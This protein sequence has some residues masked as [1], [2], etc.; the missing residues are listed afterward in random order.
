VAQ[1]LVYQAVPPPLS[2]LEGVQQLPPGRILV[3]DGNTVKIRTYWTPPRQARETVRNV[4]EAAELVR[5]ELEQAVRRQMMSERPLGVFL[6]GGVDSSALVAMAARQVSHRLQTFSVGF[7][8]ADEQVLT[9]WPWAKQVAE[10]YDTD[11]HEVVLTEETFRERLPHVLTS[12]DQPTSD[13]INSYYVSLAASKGVTVAL[14]GTGGDELFLGYGR[15]AALLNQY[16]QARRFC[17][18]PPRYVLRIGRMLAAIPGDM[19]WPSLRATQESALTY[20]S[21]AAQFVSQRGIAIFEERERN[22]LLAPDVRASTD[23]FR[24]KTVFLEGDV[25]PDPAKPGDWISRL[26]QRGYMSFVL[27][28]DIDAMSMC[29]SLEVRVP[30]LDTK[31]GKSMA[32]IP[33]QW[34]LREGVGKWILKRALREHLPAAILDRPKMGFGLPCNVWMRRSLE[35]IVREALRPESVRRHRLLNDS[36]VKSL[37]DRFYAGDDRIWRKLW[38][39]FVLEAWITHQLERL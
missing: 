27:L 21:L 33:W 1:Y 16:E 34:K 8:G 3:H 9:E 24:D 10:R 37:V 5:S 19:I 25:P 17:P 14:S 31:F 11:H 32:Q 30:F 36:G 23:R 26:E 28:R 13:G 38:T 15:D 35:P 2:I 22:E 29:H 20:A 39:V 4:D 7:V 12:M 6:S 18:L